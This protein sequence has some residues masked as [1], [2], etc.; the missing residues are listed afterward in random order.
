MIAIFNFILTL[1]TTFFIALWIHFFALPYAVNY[2]TI[3]KQWSNKIIEL[4]FL[5]CRIIN[6]HIQITFYKFKNQL[7]QWKKKK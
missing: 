1:I 7:T 5:K 6:L 4:F 3:L 2:I